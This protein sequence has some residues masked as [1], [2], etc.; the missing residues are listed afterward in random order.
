MYSI[1][2]D[3]L[4]PIYNQW[5]IQFWSKDGKHSM[6][7]NATAQG[8][9]KLFKSFVDA[10][11]CLGPLDATIPEGLSDLTAGLVAT[12]F[13][14]ASG[15]SSDVG[16]VEGKY[17]LDMV[18]LPQH[19]KGKSGQVIDTP[20]LFAIYKKGKNKQQAIDFLSWFLTNADAARAEGM[21]RGMYGTAKLREALKGTFKGY[22]ISMSNLL[23]AVEAEKNPLPMDDP[24]L[25]DKF[26][27]I[28]TPEREKL[29]YGQL[30]LEEF[31]KSVIKNADPVLSE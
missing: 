11:V 25:R 6:F 7:D 21:I 15:F 18:R 17:D 14:P 2:V 8:I 12:T 26:E 1:P 24:Q 22:D 10:K 5:G 28:L 30:T 13:G 23:N 9:W 4:I 31:F 29:I 27:D 19:V 3:G 20:M 16:V